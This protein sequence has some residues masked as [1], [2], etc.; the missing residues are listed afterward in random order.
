KTM[1]QPLR[2]CTALLFDRLENRTAKLHKRFHIATNHRE[3]P[4]K[5][6][7]LDALH[8][9]V[10]PILDRYVDKVGNLIELLLQLFR[11][12]NL[13]CDNHGEPRWFQGALLN[14]TPQVKLEL[15]GLDIDFR[16]YRT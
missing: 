3:P 5:A 14:E 11:Q 9:F 4:G 2:V 12:F 6:G 15:E 13:T 8:H 1:A 7:Q 16:G 10:P